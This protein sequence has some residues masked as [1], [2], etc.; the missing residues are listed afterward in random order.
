M[1]S[2]TSLV[3][4][5]RTTGASSL[6]RV[7]AGFTAAHAS[8]SRLSTTMGTLTTRAF[9]LR[10]QVSTVAGAYRSADGL[11]RNA[12]GTLVYQRNH[13]RTVNTAFG[14]LVGTV[15]SAG[16][17]MSDSL[18]GVVSKFGKWVPL[19]GLAASAAVPLLGIIGSL[20][21]VLATIPGALIAGAVGFGVLRAAFNDLG[22]SI[23]QAL[24]D[25]N[26]SIYPKEREKQMKKLL[27]SFHYLGPKAK[28]FAR[29]AIEIG[30]AWRKTSKVI[31]ESFF[32][33][34]LS[35]SLKAAA[36]NVMPLAEKW[37]PK[38]ATTIGDAG[39]KL[40]DFFAQADTGKQL[41]NILEM[42]DNFLGSIFRSLTPLSQAFLDIAEAAGFDELGEGIE[43]AAQKFADW[44]REIKNDGTLQA[45]VE[46]GKKTWGQLNDLMKE[47]GGFIKAVMTGGKESGEDFLVTL[48]EVMKSWK[49][50][51][52][53]DDGQNIINAIG[54]VAVAIVALGKVTEE[55]IAGWGRIWDLAKQVVKVWLIV[56]LN[57][58]AG[59]SDG[60][61][62]LADA[63]G[64]DAMAEELRASSRKIRGICED[65]D[66]YLDG[67]DTNRI[68]NIGINIRTSGD[69]KLLGGVVKK[70]KKGDHIALAKGGPM[71][72]GQPYL[73]GEEGPELVMPR[74]NGMVYTARETAQMLAGSG[75]RALGGG[76]G[77]GQMTL[78]AG[79]SGGGD[80]LIQFLL[81]AFRNKDINLAV[82][83]Q[84]VRV[85]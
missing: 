31:Q 4:A 49:E 59:V 45:W 38:I 14:S 10:R 7:S 11:W 71:Q 8:A 72:A 55:W 81:R 78:S 1:A 41:N 5:V 69:A 6:S 22:R 28:A 26:W 16:Q 70:G 66:N 34:G 13:L 9:A 12:N 53:S 60:L 25:K 43:G 77:S 42:T 20:S 61:A 15:T 84:P 32:A 18:D 2:V 51:A 83:G 17:A 44:I 50:W 82:N 48:T 56:M 23:E 21:G 35:K 75:G 65:I 73:V 85:V 54:Y 63:M 33:T 68:I 3:V 40:L 67:I 27:D 64:M 46:E 37:F 30:L 80:P 79:P 52:Q 76:S 57:S 62:A 58:F 47:T 24:N 36:A 74:S 19:I 39:T 29:E